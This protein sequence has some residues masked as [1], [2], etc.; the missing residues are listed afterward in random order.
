MNLSKFIFGCVIISCPLYFIT[1]IGLPLS[2]IVFVIAIPFLFNGNVLRDKYIWLGLCFIPIA[3]FQWLM[4][5][6]RVDVLLS[7]LLAIL[8]FYMGLSISREHFTEQSFRLI[9]YTFYFVFVYSVVISLS[10]F[11]NYEQF[12]IPANCGENNLSPIGLLRCGTFGEGNYYGHYITIISVMFFYSRFVLTMAFLASLISYSPTAILIVLSLLILTFVRRSRNAI[13]L[14]AIFLLVLV[15]LS[16]YIFY[17]AIVVLAESPMTSF[18]ERS[19]F[20]R[21]GFHMFVNNLLIGVGLGQY[22]SNIG[23]YTNFEHLLEGY[24]LGVRYIP[25]NVFAETFSEQGIVGIMLLLPIFSRL[26]V[27]L[28]KIYSVSIPLLVILV[29]SLTMP[30]L[31]LTCFSVLIGI[32]ISN[33]YNEIITGIKV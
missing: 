9:R 2:T 15:C 3:L 29:D 18:T 28:P 11:F 21:A 33:S 31:Y 12:I 13:F 19:E 20:I 25:N 22:G 32:L 1:P 16:V 30:T 6:V 7:K 4:L 27:T 17:D 24:N 26:S 23:N 5:E 14:I 10:Y 8:L